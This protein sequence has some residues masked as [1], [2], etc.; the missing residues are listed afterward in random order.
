M[1]LANAVSEIKHCIVTTKN[2]TF[3][4]IINFWRKRGKTKDITA[5]YEL[6]SGKYFSFSTFNGLPYVAV[7]T[8]Y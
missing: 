6:G 8:G 5:S 2:K 4:A 7:D 1:Q 3:H